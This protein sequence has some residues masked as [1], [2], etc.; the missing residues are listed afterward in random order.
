MTPAPTGPQSGKVARFDLAQPDAN[1]C[2]GDRV[3]DGGQPF[4]EGFTTVLALTAE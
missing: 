1:A 3:A 2:R 4:G